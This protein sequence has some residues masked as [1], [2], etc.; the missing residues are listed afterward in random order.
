MPA[1]KRQTTG[2]KSPATT[3]KLRLFVAGNAPNSRRA[4]A[5]LDAVIQQ[6]RLDYCELEIIDVQKTPERAMIDGVLVTPTLV[7][8]S[9]KPAYHLVGDLSDH[10]KVIEALGL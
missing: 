9:P 3:Y 1:R 10:E 6:H 7:K 8:L 5:N 2:R 4:K